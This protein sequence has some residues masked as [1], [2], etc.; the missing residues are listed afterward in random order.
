MPAICLIRVITSGDLPDSPLIR[1]IPQR[2]LSTQPPAPPPPRPPHPHTAMA[3]AKR[4][5]IRNRPPSARNPLGPF[6]PTAVLS[7][8]AEGAPSPLPTTRACSHLNNSQ[9]RARACLSEPR[10]VSSRP[11]DV[12]VRALLRA[13]VAWSRSSP[14]RRCCAHHPPRMLNHRRVTSSVACRFRVVGRRGGWRSDRVR[15]Q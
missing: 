6:A 8:C 9:Q 10:R 15:R 3:V 7:I 13:A 4:S 2:S 1:A 12:R 5:R 14:P 11:F